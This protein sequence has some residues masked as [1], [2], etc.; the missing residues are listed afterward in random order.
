MQKTDVRALII[1]CGGW[2]LPHTAKAF[3][4]RGALAGLWITD[5]QRVDL[6][7]EHYKRCWP[8]H[9]A[10]MPFYLW[11]PQ[12]WVERA[13]YALFP[14]WKAWLALQKF[15]R[16]NV[17]HA[18]IGFATEP[19]DRAE[20][21]GALKV[22]D[23]PNS[24]PLTYYGFWQRECDLWCPGE[25]VPIPSWMFARMNRELERADVIIVQS[26]FCRESMLWN[27]IPATKIIVQP[28]G[29]DTAIF[30]QRPAVP[31]KIR[32]VCVGTICL[33]KGHQYLFRAWEIVKR[34]LPTAELICVGAYKTDFR[35]ERPRWKGRF[36]HHQ[37]LSHAEIASLL[38][39]ATAFVFPSQEE[40]I[41]RAQMEALAC[42]VPV[43]GTHEGGATTVVDDGVEGFIVNGRNPQEIAA[44]MLLIAENSS[45]NEKM[46][47]AAYEKGGVSNTWQDY[48]DRLL[49]EYT[50][51]IQDSGDSGM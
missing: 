50:A 21:T 28:M 8:F 7:P 42:G 4:A 26:K 23:C 19:F 33:R 1:S 14:I 6:A 20:R 16:C 24:H 11:T 38:G 9:A 29:V 12:I 36:T 32:F 39:K 2:W 37:R 43:I 46:G 13:F 41:A 15:P 25:R 17:V 51:R 27:K 18:M 3:E 40:G 5:R 45:L 35:K 44:A 49:R 47:K 10:M 22:L 48:G 30:K 34:S 31:D